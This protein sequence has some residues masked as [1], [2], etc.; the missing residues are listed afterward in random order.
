[1]AWPPTQPRLWL[2]HS[3]VKGHHA[4]STRLPPALDTPVYNT[5]VTANI[6]M[7][8]FAMKQLAF[9]AAGLALLLG[10]V[11]A[12]VSA[13]KHEPASAA[14]PGANGKIV[15][16]SNRVDDFRV[17]VMNADGSGQARLTNNTA[18]DGAPAWS[19]D[20]SKIAFETDRDGN[21]EVYVMNADGSGQTNTSDNL[22]DDRFPAW[23]PDGLKIAF[24]SL[25]DGNY[26]I[27]VMNADG[28]V[29]T[30]LSSNPAMDFR[31]DWSPNGS[32]IAF[33]STRDAPDQSPCDD[34]GG[35]NWEVYVMNADG[36]NPTN[37]TNNPAID[38]TPAWSPDGSKITFTSTRDGPNPSSCY[39]KGCDYDVFVMNANGSGQ[40]NVTNNPASD[41]NP[42]WQPLVGV[43]GVAELPEADAAP[44]QARGSSGNNAGAIAGA[45]AALTAAVV[46]LG[47][48]AR[49]AR[50]RWFKP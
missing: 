46:A 9:G 28:N 19:P 27:Y 29:Q 17:Y 33:A 32:K 30:N 11:A 10:V 12:A 4:S 43:G 2:H 41:G 18:E 39:F 42:D 16:D 45:A 37:L 31:P 49:Y 22:A 48:A 21:F 35:C 38:F 6:P 26:E 1:L 40:T 5:G 23:S 24:Q 14:F 8:G 15:F 25:R 34:T 3:P 7:G 36:S 44:P 13:V 20:G 50:R 47:A